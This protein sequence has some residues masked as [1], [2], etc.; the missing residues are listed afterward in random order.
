MKSGARR[1]T[2]AKF[3]RTARETFL[4]F[5]VQRGKLFCVTGVLRSTQSSIARDCER[6]MKTE[7]FMWRA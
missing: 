2:A 5:D 7:L 3:D 6:E 4:K 1:E